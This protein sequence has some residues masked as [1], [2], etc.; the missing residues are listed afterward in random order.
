MFAVIIVT[1]LGLFIGSTRE[2]PDMHALESAVCKSCVDQYCTMCG[3]DS[4][5]CEEC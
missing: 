3:D 1:V 2:C 5:Q 4:T